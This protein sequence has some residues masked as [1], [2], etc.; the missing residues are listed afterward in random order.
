MKY[1]LEL[2]FYKE[3]MPLKNLKKLFLLFSG[4]KQH[5]KKKIFFFD[6][7]HDTLPLRIEAICYIHA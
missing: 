7:L 5:L 3:N 2:V 6:F 4:S 1:V